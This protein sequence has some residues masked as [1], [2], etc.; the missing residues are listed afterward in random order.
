VKYLEQNVAAASLSLSAEDLSALSQMFPRDSAAG[1]RY[2][3]P[4][5]KG[6]GI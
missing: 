6:L 3:E 1:T 5:L 2:P 4:A